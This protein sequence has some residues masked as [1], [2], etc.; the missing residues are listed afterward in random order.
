MKQSTKR[1]YF[2]KITNFVERVVRKF[3]NYQEPKNPIQPPAVY[4]EIKIETIKNRKVVLFEE[5]HLFNNSIEEMEVYVRQA[6]CR[7]FSEHI[8][9]NKLASFK[10]TKQPEN[11]QY[12]FESE[13]VI[14]IKKAQL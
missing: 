7:E 1:K 10:I 9:K 3:L 12:L 2:F 14:G 6:V 11:Q 13:L 4:Q 8:Y 5:S